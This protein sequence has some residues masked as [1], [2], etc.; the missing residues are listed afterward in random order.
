MKLGFALRLAYWESRHGLRR[1]GVYM[2]SITLGVGALVSIHSFRTDVT[3]ALRE[4]AE[5]LMG[6]DAVLEGEQPLPRPILRM[7]DSLAAEGYG[8]SRVTTTTSMVMAARTGDV[9][10]MQVQAIDGGFPFYGDVRTEPQGMWTSATARG[11]ALVD[12][13]ALAQL[14]I[15]VGDS[16]VVGNLE[17]L[18]AGTAGNVPTDLGMQT[19]IGPRIYVSHETL[20]RAGVM[21]FGSLAR[22][23]AYLRMPDVEERGRLRGRYRD[24]MREASISFTLSEE[25]ARR[26]SNGIRFLGRFLAL[27]GLGALL[28]GGV[29]VASAI[30]VYAREKRASVAVLR[31]LGASQSTPFAAYLLQAAGLGLMGAAAGVV[32]GV[33]VQQVLPLLLED[34][35]P[36]PV[37]ATVSGASALAGLGIGVWVAVIFAIIPLLSVRN[38][39]PL[40]A[41]RQD[42][43]SGAPGMGP[44][45]VA[46]YVALGASVLALCVLEAPEPDVGVA[47]A[48]ALAG[49]IAALAAVGWTL[50]R[51]TRRFFPRGASYPI[52][53]GVSNL[54][55]PQ[56]QTIAVTLALGFGAFVIGTVLEVE[57]NVRDDLAISFGAGRPNVLVFDVQPDQ[58]DGVLALLPAEARASV[59]TSPLVTSRIAS[60]NGRTPD[61]L[62]A[63]TVRSRRPEGWAVRREY[64][65]TYRRE[66]SGGE[67][68]VAGRWWDG[69]PGEDDGTRID[70]GG[71]TRLSLE[72]DVAESLR[73]G[74]G[75]TIVWDVAGV[76]VPSVVTSLRE[77]DWDRLE[78]NFF[79]VLEPGALE[80]APQ[81]VV[82]L[83]RVDLLG[84]RA[85]FQRRLLR[86]FPNVSVLDF[87][88]VQEAVDAVLSNVRRAVGFLGAFSALA[89]LL[90]LVGALATSRLRRL[91]EG[92]LLRTLGARRRQVLQVLLAEYLA[93]GTVATASGLLLSEAAAALIVPG[94]LDMRFAVHPELPLLLW[95]AV[96]ALTC[97]V[98]LLGS[99]G[100]LA[101]PPLPLLRGTAE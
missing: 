83:A 77:V 8:V 89:G 95:L 35:V 86:T 73:V 28:L 18:V 13:A 76:R 38:V 10:L 93:L 25:R 59:A 99:R 62:R 60:I 87:S 39:P 30:H 75:D 4:E 22:H 3:R 36:V 71:L 65:N 67:R 56:N 90:V 79:A 48:A 26:L 85:D 43:D 16:V 5:V 24:L 52:R 97:T 15:G 29:G 2:T 68:L 51:L 61:E 50:T 6:A 69:S 63:D 27:V 94:V 64:R 82:L 37:R 100:L 54:F 66:L 11:D 70:A 32:L 1:L 44:A 74:L 101:R 55:R 34:V 53:Q 20:E 98:G 78:P 57:R 41:L 81:I 49:S 88:R 23:E 7:L 45:H 33:G 14:G 9:R 12:E 80:D 40:Q 17:L 84:E 46:A 72:L 42:F 91:R 21:A 96:V 19:A 58:L 92:A 31:C 47:F